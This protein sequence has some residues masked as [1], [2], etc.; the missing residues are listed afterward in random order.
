M[1]Y[2][3][4]MLVIVF[5]LSSNDFLAYRCFAWYGCCRVLLVLPPSSTQPQYCPLSPLSSPIT[6]HLPPRSLDFTWAPNRAFFTA[7]FRQMQAVGRR[8]CHRAAFELCKL[9]LSLDPSADPLGALQCIDFYAL[10][11]R[12]G[13]WLAGFVAQWDSAGR[14][15]ATLPNFAFALAMAKF[16]EAEQAGEEEPAGLLQDRKGG[17]VERGEAT[18]SK[19]AGEGSQG[20]GRCWL[21]R[22]PSADSLLLDALLLH[23]YV[24]ARL[25]EKA[26]VKTDGVGAKDWSR[27]LRHELFAATSAG[28][29]TLQHLVELYVERSASLWRDGE[30]QVWLLKAAVKAVDKAER[31]KR[32][33][34][35]GEKDGSGSRT[36]D[37]AVATWACVR[38]QLFQEAKN[39]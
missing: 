31:E 8:G 19:E 14:P 5:H 34:G 11:A 39:E 33:G 13:R 17:R 9:L 6:P 30:A 37:G 4:G 15:A 25:V 28:S 26:P 20:E 10:R 7:V 36:D 22:L 3:T 27:V 29:A 38:G 18:G 21:G 1:V 16:W 12:Q 2:N 23:P 24:L 35:G 32:S